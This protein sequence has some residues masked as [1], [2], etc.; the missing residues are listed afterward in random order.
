MKISTGMIV[1]VM[2]AT[3]ITEP[4]VSTLRSMPENHI[5]MAVRA[6]GEKLSTY[7]GRILLFDKNPYGEVAVI[8]SPD[9]DP[10]IIAGR[11]CVTGNFRRVDGKS[12]EEATRNGVRVVADAVA[13]DAY[14]ITSR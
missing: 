13:D 4:S 1:A 2:F 7:N 14:W 8:I 11:I 12:Y 9:V 6:C 10:D 5:G 3:Q